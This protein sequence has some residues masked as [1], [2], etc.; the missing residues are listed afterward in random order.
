MQ[1]QKPTKSV[2]RS[3]RKQD[4]LRYIC[5][6]RPIDC[7]GR[8]A[9]GGISG[10]SGRA[11]GTAPDAGF[12]G[13]TGAAVARGAGSGGA[14][15][16]AGAAAFRARAARRAG[17]D[18]A[19]RDELFGACLSE[20]APAGLRDASRRT[21]RRRVRQRGHKK[22]RNDGL[23]DRELS[24]HPLCAR[25]PAG[26]RKAASKSHRVLPHPRRAR[27][28]KNDASSR[29]HPCPV[30]FRR[31]YVRLRRPGR[32][33]GHDRRRRAVRSRA[34]DG[35]SDRRF[36]KRR[37]DAPSARDE[38]HMDRGG[39]NYSAAGLGGYGADQLLRCSAPCN[40]ACEGFAGAQGETALPGAV[41]P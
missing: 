38:P 28:G 36:K 2:G 30:Q 24:L 15:K 17:R 1:V 23:S 29:M 19:A 32:N 8:D 21:P 34:A 27:R 20:R 31:A 10:N 39:R 25:Y 33:F 11:S 35:C 6:Q 13:C 18:F 9:D 16:R 40:G 41:V 12:F 22:R 4:R 3:Q 5:P 26:R 7:G 14:G 37:H